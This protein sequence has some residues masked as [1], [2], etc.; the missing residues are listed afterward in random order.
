MRAARRRGVL[1]PAT[2]AI[3]PERL[4]FTATES[5]SES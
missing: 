4:V 5:K 3:D 2:E 1:A